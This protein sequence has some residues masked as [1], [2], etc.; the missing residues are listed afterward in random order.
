[1]I[2]ALNQRCSIALGIADAFQS[3][4]LAALAARADEQI[5]RA[6]PMEA[7]IQRRA[8]G[9]DSPLSYAQQRLWFIDR[10][11]GGSREYQIVLPV[12]LHG[13]LDMDAVVAAL[14]TIIQRHDVLRTTYVEDQDGRV[15]QHV[16]AQ[17][18]FAL[19]GYR[20][21]R[22]CDPR[23]QQKRL[24]EQ[25]REAVDIDADLSADPV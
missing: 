21:L 14:T 24:D 17:A 4:T 18:A 7:P 13:R 2:L 23:E 8:P 11:S 1:M 16:Q 10:L 15:L 20:D 5:A 6:H 9:A 25:L 19:S 3:Q 12:K 22:T